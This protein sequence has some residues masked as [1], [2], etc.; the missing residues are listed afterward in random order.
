MGAM[1]ELTWKSA[2]LQLN[3]GDL[4]L[5]YTDGVVE[6]QNENDEFFNEEQLLRSA[7]MNMTSSADVIHNQIMKDLH[8][9]IGKAAQFDDITMLTLKR[10]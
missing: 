1:E 6:A 8:S 10:E 7:K 5:F 4:L 3:K 9:F 2:S